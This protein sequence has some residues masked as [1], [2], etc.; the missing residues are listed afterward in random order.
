M[1][2]II[3]ALYKEESELPGTDPKLIGVAY[4]SMKQQLIY[5]LN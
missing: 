5:P 4:F 1:H 3:H 2:R